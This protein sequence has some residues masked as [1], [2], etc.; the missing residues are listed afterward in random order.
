MSKHSRNAHIDENTL[1]TYVFGQELLLC[2]M[3]LSFTTL[4]AKLED[5]LYEKIRK[6]RQRVKSVKSLMLFWAADVLQED[7]QSSCLDVLNVLLSLGPRK[8]IYS[9]NT[10]FSSPTLWLAFSSVS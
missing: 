1:C 10:L 9:I 4:L 8:I 2:G 6:V 3:W 7:S 5:H